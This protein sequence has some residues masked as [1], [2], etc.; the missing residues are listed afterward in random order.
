MTDP[1]EDRLDALWVDP[2]KVWPHYFSTS[3]MHGLHDRCRRECKFCPEKC[4][5]PCH[6]EKES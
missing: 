3:C 5:C 6:A 1:K 4:R 2:E